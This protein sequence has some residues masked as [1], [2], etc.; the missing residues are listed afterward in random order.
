MA[1]NFTLMICCKLL[2]YSLVNSSV[3]QVRT[4]YNFYTKFQP[5]WVY[6]QHYIKKLKCCRFVH[7][8]AQ[9]RHIMA[10]KFS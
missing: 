3:I 10:A 7:F 6:L 2:W 8:E 4:F 5:R 9:W 1:A